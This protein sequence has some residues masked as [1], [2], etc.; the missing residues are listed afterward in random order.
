MRPPTRSRSAAAANSG[1]AWPPPHCCSLPLRL[2]RLFADEVPD[3]V[4][5][6][7][8]RLRLEDVRIV[9]VEAR[10]DDGLDAA[11]PRR[12]HRDALGEKHRLLHI[13]GDEDHGL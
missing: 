3:L 8:E 13:V 10:I 7:D 6:V 1:T 12:H 5:L 2:D 11:G 4:D 9:L